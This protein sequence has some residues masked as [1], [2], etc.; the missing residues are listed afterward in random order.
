MLALGY[1]QAFSLNWA[2]FKLAKN[3]SHIFSLD[4]AFFKKCPI[5][6]K[7]LPIYVQYFGISLKQCDVVCLLYRFCT[8]WFSETRKRSDKK[9]NT[10]LSTIYFG[11]KNFSLT[12]FGTPFRWILGN[13]K[14]NARNKKNR[15]NYAGPILLQKKIW[16]CHFAH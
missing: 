12:D 9:A 2:F 10:V 7:C 4:W 11:F 3:I 5:K 1:V 6:W 14:C 16:I 8:F 13:L 15:Y